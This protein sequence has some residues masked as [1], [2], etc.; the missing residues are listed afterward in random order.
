MFKFLHAADIHLDSPLRGLG[1]SDDLPADEIRHSTRRAL[2]NLVRTA[3][4][5]RVAFVLIAGDVYDGDWKDHNTGLWFVRQMARLRD[6]GIRVFLIRGNHDAQNKMTANLPLPDNVRDFPTDRPASFRLDDYDVI[7]HG[8]G[9]ASG[10]VDE[11]LASRYPDP[12]RG[13]LNIGLLH[14]S[15]NGRDG[16]DPYAPCTVD[17]LKRKGYDYWALG[18]VHTRE[19]LCD[20]GCHIAFPGN[21]QGRHIREAGA[22]GCLLVTVDDRRCVSS[23]EFTPL[24]VLRWATCR[25]DADGAAD[26]EEL[27]GRFEQAAPALLREHGRPIAMRVEIVG[28]CPAH[29]GVAA[30]FP[31]FASQIRSVALNVGGGRLWVEKVKLRT[32]SHAGLDGDGLGD[33]AVAVLLETLAELHRDPAPLSS[34]LADLRKR[35]GPAAAE[36]ESV[37]FDDPA[38]FR[39]ILDDAR[40][41][42]ITRLCR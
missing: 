1:R 17:A 15:A 7:V 28:D 4:D 27:L 39:S 13:C 30:R 36:F 29:D 40:S 24:D 21:V 5:E 35:L 6:S 3:I 2:D 16:H 12:D 31:E 33:D 37:R 14:T 19:T 26:G 10:R 38:W 34:D 9:F 22:K 20:V 8:Q 11:D 25:V 41:L 18:H 42:L 23:V 32:T